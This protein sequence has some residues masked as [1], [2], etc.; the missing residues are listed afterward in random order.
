M[1]MS[2]FEQAPTNI[3]LVDDRPENL[4]SLQSILE[5]PDYRLFTASSGNDALKSVL[6]ENF[7]VILLDVVMPEMD[8]FEVAQYL[9]QVERTRHTP[10]LFLT[11][12]ATDVHYIYRA[13]EIGAVDYLIK[14]LDAEIVRKKVA[15]FVELARQREEIAWQ[16]E[17]LRENQRREYELRLAELRVAS[18]RRYHKLIEGIDHAI[19]WSADETLRLTFVSLRAQ[20]ILGYSHDDLLDPEFWEKRLHAEDRERVM[21]TFRGVLRSDVDTGDLL[22]DHR[23]MSADDRVVWFHTGL[24]RTLDEHRRPEIHGISVEVTHIKKAEAVQALLADAGTFFRNRST[25]VHRCSAWRTASSRS[26]VIGA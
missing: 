7:T 17:R 19:G 10:I 1:T 22:I 6:R 16:A 13:Y 2:D 21:T 15:V 18:D 11:A 14:P 20:K 4:S 9:K 25:I 5:R 12:I 26:S 23:L 24:S 3:L 8:G